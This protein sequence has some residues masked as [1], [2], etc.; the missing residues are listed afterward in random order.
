MYFDDHPMPHFH[1]RYAEWS[2]AI[3]IET[4]AV[5]KGDLPGR[6]L[7]LVIEWAR[8]HQDELRIDWERARQAQDLLPI[9]PL[10]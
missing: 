1:A 6:A 10:G 2:V 5:V 3:D 8:L 9:E 4:L 7:G